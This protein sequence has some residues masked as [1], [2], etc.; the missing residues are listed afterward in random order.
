MQKLPYVC[1]CILI[2]FPDKFI[3]GVLY[4]P[5]Y[6]KHFHNSQYNKCPIS[7]LYFYHFLYPHSLALIHHYYTF[8]HEN[9]K[10]NCKLSCSKFSTER[11][12]TSIIHNVCD[13]YQRIQPEI[14]INRT[15]SHIPSFHFEQASSHDIFDILGQFMLVLR[16]DLMYE[17]SLK[18]RTY[19]YEVQ[20]DFQTRKYLG[21]K[22]LYFVLSKR[23]KYIYPGIRKE[24]IDL[25]KCVIL[26]KSNICKY[27]NVLVPDEHVRHIKNYYINQQKLKIP[28][29]N[30]TI[31]NIDQYFDSHIL[32]N[33]VAYNPYDAP[34]IIDKIFYLYKNT[35]GM[36][37][38]MSIQK[39]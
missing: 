36:F 27:C 10:H 11:S 2:V 30:V 14:N 38:V 17:V 8:P 18:R 28:E 4:T 29:T 32:F 39:C 15:Y 31:N 9:R 3:R 34:G 6:D 37:S 12:H 35:S 23:L 13:Y 20:D 16:N 21:Q 22:L 5:T 7:D 33:Y 1:W 24:I 25:I 26:K 19:L